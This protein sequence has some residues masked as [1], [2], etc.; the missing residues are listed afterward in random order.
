MSKSKKNDNI[1]VMIVPHG[2]SKTLSLQ[3]SF[4]QIKVVGFLLLL[5]TLVILHLA[6][7]FFYVQRE[8]GQLSNEKST[9]E[10]QVAKM[11]S[12]LSIDKREFSL[13]TDQ[14]NEMKTYV[15][16]L[17][18]LETEIRNKSGMLSLPTAENGGKGGAERLSLDSP[19]IVEDSVTTQH[20]SDTLQ[21]LERVIPDKIKKAKHL[22]QDVNA[23]NQKLIHTPSIFPAI[24]VI[25]SRFGYRQDPFH[26]ATRF[27]DGFDI[28]NNF[29]T[30]VIATASG[31]VIFAD[32]RQG[33]GNTIH[34][35]HSKTIQ[36]SYSHLTEMIVSAGD[37]VEKGQVIGYMGSTGRST[38][39]HVHYMVYQNGQPIDPEI[40][41]TSE[42]RN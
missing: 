18:Q 15:Q 13:L 16:Q 21:Q 27:H 31:K 8:N 25:T 26:G 42:G 23:L 33:Y 1:T 36:T 29:R 39:V 35:T 14:V 37:S 28:A 24:G 17:E 4:S 5:A 9:L 34:I 3:L 6:V 2:K 10:Q 19:V 12:V 11:N 7:Y 41:L 32:R 40:F 20:P 22:L 38:G 30:P